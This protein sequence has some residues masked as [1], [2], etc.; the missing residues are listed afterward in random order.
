V[1]A[2]VGAGIRGSLCGIRGA[3]RSDPQRTNAGVRSV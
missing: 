2:L 3:A 1:G